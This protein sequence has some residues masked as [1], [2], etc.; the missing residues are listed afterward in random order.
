MSYSQEQI[1]SAINSLVDE[2]GM[3]QEE[4]T[5]AVLQALQKQATDKK[6]PQG[7]F[8]NLRTDKERIEYMENL[9]KSAPDVWIPEEIRKA[10][11]LANKVNDNG[12]TPEQQFKEN[13]KAKNPGGQISHLR[14]LQDATEWFKSQ[15]K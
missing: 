6:A 3:S 4:A 11:E 8:F 12:L 13:M 2:Q 10:Q 7:G 1:T 5:S 9:R 14:N 15:G